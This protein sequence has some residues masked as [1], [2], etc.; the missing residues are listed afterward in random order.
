MKE[1]T[2]LYLMNEH[3]LNTIT[4]QKKKKQEEKKAQN[5]H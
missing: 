2:T 1:D 4:T 3:K 5:F